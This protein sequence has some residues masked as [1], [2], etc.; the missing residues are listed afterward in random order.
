AYFDGVTTSYLHRRGSGLPPAVG[1]LLE[2]TGDD[3]EAARAAALQIAA[4]K[5]QFLRREDV[6]AE[7]VD[8]EKHIAEQSAREE[9]KP[10][11]AIPK[12]IEGKVNAFYKDTV[13][14]EQ[15]SVTDNK[16]TAGDLLEAA[17]V[18]I[19]RFQRFEI[20]QE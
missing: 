3:A 16:Q 5:P 18:T 6:P 12:I 7:K 8:S 14:L 15:P 19:E 11:Q 4:M 1:V 9:G 10:E 17:G 2:Y 13:L 20:G